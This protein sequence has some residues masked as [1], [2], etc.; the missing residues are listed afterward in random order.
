MK[1]QKVLVVDDNLEIC[2]ML[3]DVFYKSEEFELAGIAHDGIMALE[4]VYKDYY[5]II[6]LDIAMPKL[7]GIGFLERLPS[8]YENSKPTIIIFS[9]IN[10]DKITQKTM[11]LGADYFIIKPFDLKELLNRIRYIHFYKNIKKED[12]KN[13]NDILLELGF[14]A[15]L[16]GYAYLKEAVELVKTRE[17]FLKSIGKGLYNKVAEIHETTSSRVERSIRHAITN[18]W[19]EDANDRLKKLFDTEIKFKKIKPSNSE[20]IAFL[21]DRMR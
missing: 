13:V 18:A 14:S 17:D 16:R 2:E 6:I 10:Q 19:N 11:E 1:K 8:F 7:D 4:M 3:K 15:N 12:E 20:L 21:A 9:A 5:D